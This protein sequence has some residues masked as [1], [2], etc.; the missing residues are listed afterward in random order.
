[1]PFV[2]APGIDFTANEDFIL[3]LSL[4]PSIFLTIESPTICVFFRFVPPLF[5]DVIVSFKLD[6]DYFCEILCR[7]H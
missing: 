2:V 5:R 7:C 6:V 4:H 3:L 1:M